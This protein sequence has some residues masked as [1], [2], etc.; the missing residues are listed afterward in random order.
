MKKISK[1]QILLTLLPIAILLM[2]LTLIVS[3]IKKTTQ[4]KSE[5]GVADTAV[6][7]ID[8]SSI[9]LDTSN[10]KTGSIIN[11]ID[12]DVAIDP[13]GK[14]LGASVQKGTPKPGK[15]ICLTD[16]VEDDT[17]QTLIWKTTGK[18]LTGGEEV[19]YD[20]WKSAGSPDYAAC[21][22]VTDSESN[23]NV[24]Q[25]FTKNI[26]NRK[27]GNSAQTVPSLTPTATPTA[28]PTPRVL[29]D[30]GV[31]KITTQTSFTFDK[32]DINVD[33]TTR[34]VTF[35]L[36]ATISPK[37]LVQNSKSIIHLISIESTNNA[38]L[39]HV[40]SIKLSNISIK[41]IRISNPTQEVELTI[42]VTTPSPTPSVAP[43]GSPVPVAT[44]LPSPLNA[45]SPKPTTTRSPFTFKTPS[46]SGNR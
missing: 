20:G 15:Q 12:V 39:A 7:K 22:A 46:P 11:S 38:P 9:N 10:L 19:I 2:G 5:A 13:T 28:T 4:N 21:R 30:T 6:L 27:R 43:S 35:H 25:E 17:N 44:I 29:A 34:I 16:V 24:P 33:K 14:V 3:N 8:N 32:P 31:V 1:K 36:H 23:V 40:P 37:D 42:P 26:F 18:P 45:G 41:G